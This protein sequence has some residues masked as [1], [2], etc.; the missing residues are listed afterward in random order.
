MLIFWVFVNCVHFLC[1]CFLGFEFSRILFFGFLSNLAR[2][3]ESGKNIV[4][5]VA[6]FIVQDG[7]VQNADLRVC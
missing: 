1:L 3:M 2:E 6:K 4:A 5:L 7:F